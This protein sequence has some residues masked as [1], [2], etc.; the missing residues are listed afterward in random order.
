[1]SFPWLEAPLAHLE[2]LAAS[3]R[4][5]HALLICGPPGWGQRVLAETFA[6]SLL[7]LDSDLPPTDIAHPDFR[8]IEPDREVIRVPQV[9]ALIEFA[10]G[11]RQQAPYKVGVLV[12]VHRIMNQ[13]ANALLKTLE[14]PPPNTVL[15]LVTEYSAGLL[16]TVRSRCQRVVIEPRF[17]LGQAWLAQQSGAMVQELSF[18]YGGAPMAV[19]SALA[20]EES[21]LL[22]SLAAG[23]AGKTE[24]LHGQLMQADRETVLLRWLRY[25]VAALGNGSPLTALNAIP[26]RKLLVFQEELLEVHRQLSSQAAAS[27][28]HR[29]QLERLSLRFASL[30]R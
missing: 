13:A 17:D 25:L 26:A 12:D 28:N 3:D 29:A 11:T 15:M 30:T 10:I 14:E 22:A 24:A 9:R 6:K 2:S 1:M 21:P 8:W 18:E 16:P 19:Q 5:P 7:A 20:R 27:V 23:L 4:M